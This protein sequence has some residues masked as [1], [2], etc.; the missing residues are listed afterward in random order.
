VSVIAIYRKLSRIMTRDD[1]IV[2]LCRLAAESKERNFSQV[3]LLRGSG[4]LESEPIS[5]EN[6][7]A[8][9]RRVSRPG[10]HLDSEL[11]GS[12]YLDG[13]VDH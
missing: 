2:F 1:L 9:L 5:E 6:I 3:D 11:G 12:A 10:G 7:E 4:Y 8:H 13:V